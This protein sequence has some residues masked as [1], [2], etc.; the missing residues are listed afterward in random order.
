M[1]QVVVDDDAPMR[2]DVD[3]ADVRTVYP[4]LPDSPRSRNAYLQAR[5]QRAY[6]AIRSAFPGM[7]PP[8]KPFPRPGTKVES[9]RLHFVRFPDTLAYYESKCVNGRYCPTPELHSKEEEEYLS[10]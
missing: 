5:D 7:K 10:S 3:S 6:L 2:R 8:S 9:L 1:P 4:D